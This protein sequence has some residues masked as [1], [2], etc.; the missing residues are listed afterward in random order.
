MINKYNYDKQRWLWLIK[1]AM[2]NKDNC[3]CMIKY[4]K[5][6]NRKMLFMNKNA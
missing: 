1:I 6:E 2:I 3:F 5:H 4:R